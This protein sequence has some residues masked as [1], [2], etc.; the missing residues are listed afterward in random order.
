MTG[1]IIRII[2]RYLVGMAIIGS[3]EIGN[4]LATDPDIVMALSALVGVATEAFY[5]YA[6]KHNWSL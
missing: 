3:P 1:A 5:V 4:Q 6:K 2:L